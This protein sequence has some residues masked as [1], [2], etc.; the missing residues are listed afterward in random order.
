MSKP[1]TSEDLCL[2]LFQVMDSFTPQAIVEIDQ[3]TLAAVRE[4]VG[5][6]AAELVEEHLSGQFSN[7]SR[8]VLAVTFFFSLPANILTLAL[9]TIISNNCGNRLDHI[10]LVRCQ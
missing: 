2:E 1:H 10:M 6:L 5:S 9:S 3:G 8:E 4:R 7:L